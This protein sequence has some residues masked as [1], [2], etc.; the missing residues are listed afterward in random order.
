MLPENTRIQDDQTMTKIQY[1]LESFKNIQELIRFIDQKAG[2][3]LIVSGLVFT[4]L[5]QRTASLRIDLSKPHPVWGVVSLIA[6]L[7]TLVTLLFTIFLTIF[8][9]LKPRFARN[10]G[11]D[12]ISLFYFEHIAKMDAV[13]L[14]E[15]YS[16]LNEGQMLQSLIE[17]QIEISNIAK[18]KTSRLNQSLKALFLS[19]VALF[20]LIL[21]TAQL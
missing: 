12:T 10:Y 9:V 2:G 19:I 1:A 20:L 8:R 15:R 17:Q 3:I 11:S 14:M 6:G 13:S 4:G 7:A 18:E 5:I 21:S 16:D